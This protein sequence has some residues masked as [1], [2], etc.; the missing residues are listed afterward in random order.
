MAMLKLKPAKF[1]VH[2][3]IL[4]A[5]LATLHICSYT[6][7]FCSFSP[8]NQGELKSVYSTDPLKIRSEIFDTLLI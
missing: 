6:S 3:S 5:Y 8:T 2:L 7:F 1:P 4:F